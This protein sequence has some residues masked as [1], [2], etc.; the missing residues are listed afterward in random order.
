MEA[1]PLTGRVAR[2]GVEAHDLSRAEVGVDVAAL[3]RGDAVV[4]DDVTA[5]HRAERVILLAGPLVREHR[6]NWV[7]GRWEVR[8][9]LG[10]A[11]EGRPAKVGPVEVV[12]GDVVDLLL[13]V[14]ADIA[15]PYVPG[16][17]VE[18]VAPRIA[19]SQRDDLRTASVRGDSQ[20]LAEEAVGVPRGVRDRVGRAA[21]AG[22]EVE[23]IVGPKGQLAAPVDEVAV[24]D[25]EHLAAAA[26]LD[27]VAI[28]GRTKRVDV[29]TPVPAR[30]GDVERP[31][32]P[33]PRVED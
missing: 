8:M 21:V 3:E 19:K 17:A 7:I 27:R 16:L 18:R 12:E 1:G 15:D 9:G 11:L 26:H 25:R 24:G 2:R 20:H 6:G 22:S 33:E 28:G 31:V 23:A 30:V 13:A 14:V 4:A 32:A 5:G 29:E 10:R